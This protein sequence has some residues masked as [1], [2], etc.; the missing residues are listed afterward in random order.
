MGFASINFTR[1]KVAA[2][3]VGAV[4]AAAVLGGVS[5]TSASAATH[6]ENPFVGKGYV[7]SDWA[8]QATAD[9]GSA[10]AN[11]PTGVW[12]DRIAAIEGTATAKGA[13]AHLDDALAQG[14]GYIQFVV[15]DLPGRDCAA[16]ASQGELGATEIDRYQTEYIDPL[17]AILADAKYAALNIVTVIEIDSL[18]NLVT[19]VGSRATATAAC[20][21]ML[22]N[23]NYVKGIQYA[24]NKLH[25]IT[26]VYTYID[27]GHHGWLG[28]DD[29]FG[30]AATLFATTAQGTTAGFASVDGFITNTANYGATVE[31]FLKL[32][33]ENRLSKWIDYNRYV[34]EQSYAIAFRTKLISAGFGSG[35][36]MLID[37]S[38]NGWGGPDRPTAAVTTGTVDEQV[39]GSR[40]D[41]RIHLGN[42][43]NQ[44]GAGI[45]ERPKASPAAGI[46]A[47]VWIK[48]P[49]ESD[50][51][52]SV[53]ADGKGIDG[54]CDPAYA[55]NPRN[56]N[57]M[58]GALPDAPISGAWFSAQFQELLANAYPAL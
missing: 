9:G 37:T 44:A 42:W 55:G 2:L 45:G 22:A 11:Q 49:G 29:N 34:D 51:S 21:T 5:M 4:G 53:A 24:L 18:P 23:G 15:Y 12:M 52:G 10:I 17:A 33:E 35:L 47:Y 25:A 38:R 7:N 27:A 46:D 19:N 8:A 40:I 6:V 13:R 32:T 50:G 31:P 16:L 30:A 20:D 43:C 57:N 41:R 56:N 26:N 36:G 14:A 3:A 28:W 48:P 58:S 39:D 1:R 54:M